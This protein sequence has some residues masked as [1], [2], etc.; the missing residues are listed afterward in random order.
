MLDR[1]RGPRGQRRMRACALA[2][3]LA[4]ASGLALAQSPAPAS[5]EST[6]ETAYFAQRLADARRTLDAGRHERASTLYAALLSDPRFEALDDEQRAAVLSLAA[7]AAMDSGRPAEGQSLFARAVAAGSRNPDDW[8]WQAGAA[9]DN[10][11]FL[12][13]TAAMTGFVEQWPS[14]STTLHPG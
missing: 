6:A 2:M 12:A 10:G 9:M 11:D 7:R 1:T 3:A 5:A 4:A 14:C 8:Y 13:A